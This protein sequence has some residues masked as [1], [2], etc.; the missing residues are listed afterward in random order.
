MSR[1]KR[2]LGRK[3]NV[4]PQ[5]SAGDTQISSYGSFVPFLNIGGRKV[6]PTKPDAQQLR[7]WSRFNPVIR[8]CV[9]LIK[10]RLVRHEGRFVKKNTKD[11]TDYTAILD[12]FTKMLEKPNGKD[13][14]RTFLSAVSEDLVVGDCGCFE[15]AVSSNPSRPVYLYPTDGLTMNIVMSDK[16]Y[17]YAQRVSLD[18]VELPENYQFF[19]PDEIVYTSKQV[20][21]NNPYGLSPI[22]TAFEYIKALTQTFSYS[23]D[24]ASN[25]IPKYVMNIKGIDDKILQAYREYFMMEC[26]G[27]PNLPIVSSESV[28]SHQIAPISEEATFM[29]YQQ[30]IIAIIA[31][32]FGVPPEKLAIAKSNDR[33]S[34]AEINENLL[35]DCVKPYLDCIV[36]AMNRVVEIVG[37]SDKIVYEP[38]FGDTLADQQTKQQMVLNRWNS[39]EITLDEMRGLLGDIPLGEPYGNLTITLYKAMVNRDYGINGLPN[40]TP[41]EGGE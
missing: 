36:D 32:C 37:F 16:T 40:V 13:T 17:G 5:K 21:T 10:D 28:D 15:V 9:N 1:R 22:E 19:L 18:A 33:S 14:R 3:P 23:S 30:F 11:T 2:Q 12:I 31:L 25:A 24:V 8:R 35:A 4:P 41:V 7:N 6:T 34:I 38:I 20:F 39:D 27:Q 29:Q 26:M